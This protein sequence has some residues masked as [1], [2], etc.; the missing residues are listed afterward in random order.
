MPKVVPEYKEIAKNRIINGAYIIFNSKGYH[1][2][3]MDDIAQVVGVSKA[4]LY[5]YFKSKEEILQ[6]AAKESLTESFIKYFEDENIQDPFEE[7][8]KDLVKFEDTLHLNFE[9]IALSPNNDEIS[10]INI[11]NNEKKLEV[12]RI[13][14]EKQQIKGRI[15][16]DLD[17]VILAS[18]FNAIFTDTMMRLVIGIDKK[19]IREMWDGSFS[20]ILE[21]KSNNDQKTLN[22]Y[23]SQ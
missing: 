23:F 19:V 11:E 4:S 21:N 2:S 13:F 8:Y 17:P 1:N 9:M 18:L 5:T 3:T 7:L 14:I 6:T 10:E 22:Q 16:D 15:R 20:S 12:L